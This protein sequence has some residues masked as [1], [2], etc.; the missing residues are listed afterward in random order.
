[1]VAE[2]LRL[3]MLTPQEAKSHPRRNVLS[4]SLSAKREKVDPYLGMVEWGKE[5]ILLLCS[6]GLWAPVSENEIQ[7]VV[8]GLPPQKAANKLIDIA[9]M[10]GGPDNISVIIAKMLTNTIRN[11]V[12]DDTLP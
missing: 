12:E 9:N 4:L 5:D 6:D 2:Q 3:G 10:H 7:A 8:L 1:M 11:Q